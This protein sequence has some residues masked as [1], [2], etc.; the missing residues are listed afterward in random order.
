MGR[1]PQV[2]GGLKGQWG[3]LSLLPLCCSTV[4]C[5]CVSAA[6]FFWSNFS[7]TCTSSPAGVKRI[8]V[9]YNISLHLFVLR[10]S[11]Y[12]SAGFS[13]VE[14]RSK[15]AR[16][17]AIWG[18]FVP[19]QVPSERS[20]PRYTFDKLSGVAPRGGVKKQEFMLH[21]TNS[22]HHK[23]RPVLPLLLFRPE[24][25]SVRETCCLHPRRGRKAISR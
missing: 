19:E 18:L 11:A 20:E 16:A 9:Q 14:A 7:R 6:T 24:R 10:P 25:N 12:F 13:F 15:F 3:S 2:Q 5:T 17:R 23:S 1:S 22:S 8:L 4:A 21:C